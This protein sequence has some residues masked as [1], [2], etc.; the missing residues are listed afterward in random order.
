[1]RS[2]HA[3]TV[4]T[5]APSALVD[6][7]EIFTSVKRRFPVQ[8]SP[9]SRSRPREWTVENTSSP[10]ARMVSSL[11]LI[12]LESF[13]NRSYCVSQAS[14]ASRIAVTS[15]DS[16]GS[17]GGNDSHSL[18]DRDGDGDDAAADGDGGYR[19]TARRAGAPSRTRSSM[20]TRFKGR[21]AWLTGTTTEHPKTCQH[22]QTTTTTPSRTGF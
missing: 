4:A 18:A 20:H 19:T 11:R 15:G 17:A 22:H 14:H 21:L 9:S 7:S 1:M 6:G 8:T 2:L 10:V 12:R 13:A 5:L 16:P 3:D